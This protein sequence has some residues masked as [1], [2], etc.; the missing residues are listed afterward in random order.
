MAA[1]IMR[2]LIRIAVVGHVD[3]GKSTLIGRLLHDTG[4]LPDGKLA[5]LKETSRRRGMPLEWSFALDSF[6]AERD[7]AVTIGTT[8]ILLRTAQRNYVIIDAPGHKEFLKNMLTGAAQADAAILV[9]DAVEGV[10]EQSRRHAYLLQLIGIRQ[11]LVAINK[12]DLAGYRQDRFQAVRDEIVRYLSGIG[13][14]AHLVLPVAARDGDNLT[15]PATMM[16]WHAGPT[17]LAALDNFAASPMPIELPLRLPVQNVYRIDKRRII[18]GRIESGALRVGDELLFSPGNQTASVKTIETWPPNAGPA[19]AKSGESIGITLDKP[20]FVE[21]GDLASHV[22]DPPMLTHNFRARLFW[23]GRTKLT[24]GASYRAK[25]GTWVRS[26]TVQSIDRVIDTDLLTSHEAPF[27]AANEVAEV[28]LRSQSLLALDDHRANPALGRFVLIDDHDAVAAGIISM[29][30]LADERRAA[31]GAGNLF[32]TEHLL[33]AELRAR[34]NGHRGAVVWFTGLPGAGKSTL[35]MEAER[36]LFLR[37]YQVYVLD[38]DNIRRGLNY[39][40]GFSPADRVENIRRIG[41]MAALFADAGL[42][43]ITAFISPYISDRENARRAAKSSFHE[44]YIKADLA[45]C[46]RRDPKG[47]YK[48][49]RAGDIADFTGVSAP[50]EEPVNPD[51]VVDTASQP[52]EEAVRAILDYIEQNIVFNSTAAAVT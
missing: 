18:V 32:G 17:L 19:E 1:N 51:L 31:V 35:A 43:V 12:M 14:A 29:E 22:T 44:I 46:E 7:Q 37:G 9:V 38:G 42:I 40:L 50:Y 36:R 26:I 3:H 27:V 23:F 47:L 24:V 45:T 15:M 49:A 52:V 8:Q 28:T 4:N 41:E 39:D 30:G 6:Q 33:T 21:R 11:V 16:P 48:R 5:E 34:R 25:L 20:I 13:L 10:S 2:D